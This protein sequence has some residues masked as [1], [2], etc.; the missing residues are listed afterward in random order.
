MLHADPEPAA[1]RMVVNHVVH[2]P[3]NQEAR[4]ELSLYQQNVERKE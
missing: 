4:L 2:D 3:K 1:H